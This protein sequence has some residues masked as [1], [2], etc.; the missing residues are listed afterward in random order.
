L[1]PP[2][3]RWQ[4]RRR[5]LRLYAELEQID[6]LL[7]AVQD[8]EDVVGRVQR[9]EQLDNDSAIGSF[10]KSYTDDVYKLRRDIDLVRRKLGAG[11]RPE[12]R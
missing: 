5:L 10:P 7:N 4:I 11:F 9:L 8:E 12:T 1:L 3:Y 6:P 2:A